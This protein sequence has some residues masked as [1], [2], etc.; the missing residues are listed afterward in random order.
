MAS[1]THLLMLLRSYKQFST[2]AYQTNWLV[3]MG[4]TTTGTTATG[5][6]ST[7]GNSFAARRKPECRHQA[8]SAFRMTSR[9]GDLE[10]LIGGPN[11]FIKY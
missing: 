1:I 4:A 5:R 6:R 9:T 2:A 10:W 7:A 3:A 11:E 8:L